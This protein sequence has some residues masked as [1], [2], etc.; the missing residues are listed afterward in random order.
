MVIE[1]LMS[2]KNDILQMSK[3]HTFFTQ[4]WFGECN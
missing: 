4:I 1:Y 2:Q 3:K